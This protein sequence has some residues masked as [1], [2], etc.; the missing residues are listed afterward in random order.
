MYKVYELLCGKLILI[1]Y[2][3][4]D[5]DSKKKKWSHRKK[6]CQTTHS[7]DSE[8]ALNRIEKTLPVS[9][10]SGVVAATGQN[11]QPPLLRVRVPGKAG[12]AV[13]GR[14]RLR[15]LERGGVEGGRPGRDRGRVLQRQ[16][17][18]GQSVEYLGGECVAQRRVIA[19]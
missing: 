3:Q 6:T 8:V 9:V 15:G 11:V 10:G 1:L 4:S 18:G 19:I 5:F 13:A 16:V 2:S 7:V 14:E 17:L 12:K